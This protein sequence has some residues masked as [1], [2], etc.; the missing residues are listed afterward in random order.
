MSNFVI[1][2]VNKVKIIDL[3]IENNWKIHYP[4]K[5]KCFGEHTA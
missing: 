2:E 1:L 4:Q 5:K 3:P